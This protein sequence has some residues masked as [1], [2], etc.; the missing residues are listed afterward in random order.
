MD[1]LFEV[2]KG[3]DG[4]LGL[5]ILNRPTVLNALNL[6]MILAIYAQLKEWAIDEDIKAV[7]IKSQGG[8]AFCAGGDLRLTYERCETH[9]V[10]SRD[11]FRDEY[12]LNRFIFHYPKPYISLLNG[13]T[14]GGGVGISIHGSH[15]IATEHLLFAMPETGIGFFPDVGGTYFLPR[16]P[17]AIGF[18]L[19]LTG[20]RLQSDDC[21]TLG[22][23]QN[24]IPSHL[25]TEF[26]H[27]LA[28]QPFEGQAH[29]T[30]SKIIQDFQVS[31]QPSFINEHKKTIDECFSQTTIEEILS[32]LE[33]AKQE[34]CN[35]TRQLLIK[36]SPT[37]LKVSL[38]A[39]QKG[40]DLNFDACMQQEYDLVCHFLKEHDFREGIRAIIIDK[41]Q[42]PRWQPDRLAE[43]SDAMVEKYFLSV[44]LLE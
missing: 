7:V 20:A 18:Y 26:L 28:E 1:V 32:K 23:A 40:K 5:I 21:V 37:S 14:M 42:K 31:V 29:A 36:K 19:G 43:I 11:F 44:D 4:H 17:N 16:L 41:D 2:M 27:A 15:R 34:F 30:V 33:Q 35:E 38:K 3:Q 22:I 6:E 13:I 10:A 24:K 39:L 12:K 25:L 9:D 8:R